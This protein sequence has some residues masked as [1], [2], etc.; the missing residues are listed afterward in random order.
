MSTL[1]LIGK[2]KLHTVRIDEKKINNLATVTV[3]LK[4]LFFN[5]LI[6]KTKVL[7]LHCFF[8]TLHCICFSEARW[9]KLVQKG[10]NVSYYNFDTILTK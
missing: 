3:S 6:D 5:E 7:L 8:L 9:S 2:R 10:R 4:Q 1:T